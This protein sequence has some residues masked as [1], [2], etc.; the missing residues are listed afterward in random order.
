M[1]HG[2]SC[3]R[4]LW[5]SCL[6]VTRHEG[7]TQHRPWIG[8]FEERQERETSETTPRSQTSFSSF[9]F[10]ALRDF[11]QAA[12]VLTSQHQQ[13]QR[14]RRPYNGEEKDSEDQGD[15]E[16]REGGEKE[17]GRFRMEGLSYL[18]RWHRLSRRLPLQHRGHL[19]LLARL[20]WHGA[21]DTPSSL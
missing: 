12:I 13:Q 5:P 18:P 4:G 8:F 20:P 9:S 3:D 2:E 1:G 15:D 11:D 17:E 19:L 10:C 14:R 6:V 16:K 21:R 7:S